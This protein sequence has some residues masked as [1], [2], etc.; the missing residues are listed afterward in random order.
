MLELV[1]EN[2]QVTKVEMMIE[3]G[4]TRY[5]LNKLLRRTKITHKRA[6]RQPTVRNTPQLIQERRNLAAGL[7][8]LPDEQRIYLDETGL[9]L[10]TQTEYG[11]GSSWNGSSSTGQPKPRA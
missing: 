5:T 11:W 4:V 8:N 6:H 1:A 3:L 10:H 2:P 9:N 7:I